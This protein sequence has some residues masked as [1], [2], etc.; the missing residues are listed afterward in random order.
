MIRCDQECDMF[1]MKVRDKD[2]K[3]LKLNLCQPV[4]F[5]RASLN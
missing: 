4:A 5:I 2:E 1:G 3:Q